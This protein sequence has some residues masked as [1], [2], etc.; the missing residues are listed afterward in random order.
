MLQREGRPGS[1]RASR[2]IIVSAPST[3]PPLSAHAI[4]WEKK[5]PSSII[6]RA[7][8]PAGTV[9]LGQMAISQT[10]GGFIFV[11]SPEIGIDGRRNRRGRRRSPLDRRQDQIGK[12]LEDRGGLSVCLD[13]IIF[14][15]DDVDPPNAP[16]DLFPF[17][18]S[19]RHTSNNVEPKSIRDG[20]ALYRI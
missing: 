11:L 6:L 3:H 9:G 17:R 19:L 14:D 10:S 16:R 18:E 5:L 13:W 1:E 12:A 15:D 20:Q 4:Q 7:E 2:E 8:L